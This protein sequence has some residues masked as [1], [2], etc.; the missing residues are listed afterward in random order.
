MRGAPATPRAENNVSAT[1]LPWAHFSTHAPQRSG[2]LRRDVLRD[3]EK[4][5]RIIMQQKSLGENDA[6]RVLRDMAM[7][8][9]VTVA[10]LD[11][12]SITAISGAFA[13]KNARTDSRLMGGRQGPS[14]LT[15]HEYDNRAQ[16]Q[17]RP[18]ASG[19]P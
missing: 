3:I 18:S 6:Y 1:G 7:E 14:I 13:A 4:A 8:R 11:G 5:K 2:W 12:D 10:E 19:S 9:R 16:D 17:V 15:V